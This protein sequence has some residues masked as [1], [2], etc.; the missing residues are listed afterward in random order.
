LTNVGNSSFAINAGLLL[1]E[2]EIELTRNNKYTF[3][4]KS[5]DAIVSYKT[6]DVKY[7]DYSDPTNTIDV[8]KYNNSTSKVRGVFNTYIGVDYKNIDQSTYYDIYQKGYNF[9]ND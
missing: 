8:L 2:P 9:K 3:S 5:G 1:I 6:T 7:G 4:S